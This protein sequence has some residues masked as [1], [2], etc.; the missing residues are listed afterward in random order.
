MARHSALIQLTGGAGGSVELDGVP[1]GG[2]T[3]VELTHSVGSGPPVL[4][5]D[6]VLL[7]GVE[8]STPA[9]VKVPEKTRASLI[10]LGW[11]PPD[12]A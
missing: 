11:T 4:R 12:G 7:G 1:L 5:V 6:F 8:V 9:E 2:V 10:A 3:A